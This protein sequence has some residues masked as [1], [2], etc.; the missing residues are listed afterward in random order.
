M[1]TTGLIFGAVVALWLAY[2]V[3]WYL[4]H[5]DQ[6]V[7]DPN[8]TEI[9]TKSTTVL[10]EGEL[11]ETLDAAEDDLDAVS[12][13]L[14]RRA[15]RREIALAAR[16]AA[17]RRRRLLLAVVVGLVVL[18]GTAVAGL[19]A[20]WAPLAGLG[21]LLAALVGS[22]LSVLR[23]HQRLD[24]ELAEVELGDDEATV[25]IGL[26]QP[27]DVRDDDVEHSVEISAPVPAMSLWDPIPVQATSYLQ[28]PLAARTVR[29]IDLS[30]PVAPPVRTE[31][32]TAGD[33]TLPAGDDRRRAVGE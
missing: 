9:V 6:S 2:L 8:P 13:P 25:M 15:R 27:G 10:K 26:E 18:V 3:P 29:T 28:R 21:L 7:E 20:W 11:V 4:S 5:R 12:T 14:I 17:V 22:R 31:P 32:V 30:A 19:T 1:G 16:R 24:A 23:L 33:D